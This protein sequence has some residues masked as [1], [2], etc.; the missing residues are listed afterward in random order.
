MDLHTEM[1]LDEYQAALPELERLLE[2][3][4]TKLRE[5]LERNEMLVTTVE[6]RVKTRSSLEG[7]LALKGAK[8]TTLS[9]ITDLVGARIVTFYTDDVDRIASMV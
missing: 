6:G 3:V 2:K 1:L 5:A 9:D 8:Y 7:K 4:L